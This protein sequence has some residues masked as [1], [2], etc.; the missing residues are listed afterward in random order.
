MYVYLNV[1]TVH[2]YVCMHLIIAIFEYRDR[3]SARESTSEDR[4]DERL[5]LP[6]FRQR[7]DDEKF[8]VDEPWTTMGPSFPMQKR[9]FGRISSPPHLCRIIHPHCLSSFSPFL[10]LSLSPLP[11]LLLLKRIRV[12]RVTHSL[13]LFDP[14]ESAPQLS[15]NLCARE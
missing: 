9:Y 7:D 12:F 6:R 11:P 2:T 3:K 1:Y 5:L 8:V 14:R 13:R 15:I 4:G 10:S